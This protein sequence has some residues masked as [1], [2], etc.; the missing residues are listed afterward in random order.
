ME[1]SENTIALEK[2]SKFYG[3][4]LALDGVNFSIGRGEIVG[5]LGP[6]GAGKSTL[7]QIAAGLFAPDDGSVRVFDMDYRRNSSA[8]LR[9]LGVVFQARSLDLD[10]SASANLRFHGQLFGLSGKRLKERIEAVAGFLDI[11]DLLDQLVR[12]LSGGNQRRVDIARALLNQPRLLLMDEP[13]VGLDTTARNALV[14]HM[15]RERDERGTA[16]LWAT[17]LVEEVAQADRIILIAKG[18]VVI[19]GTPAEVVA[20]AGVT[21]LAE[22]YVSLTG[23][24]RSAPSPDEAVVD[25]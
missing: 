20:A 22:A 21:T 19:E 13:S 11:V 8:I 24:S 4:Q 2:V 9:Q 15:Q 5:L 3:D 23:G 25:S 10:M 16:I 1:Q 17:H 12:T 7:F 14:Q 6:N 18:R